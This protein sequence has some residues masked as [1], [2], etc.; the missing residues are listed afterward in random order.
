MFV[1]QKYGQ[2]EY[3]LFSFETIADGDSSERYKISI[4]NV[5]RSTDPNNRFGTFDVQVRDFFDSDT[6]SKILE[7]YGGCTL[8]PSDEKL[9]C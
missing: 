8:N 4:A 7:T 3:N 5:Q 1:S 9:Y 2:I 6:D